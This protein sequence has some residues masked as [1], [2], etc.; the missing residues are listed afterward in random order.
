MGSYN[1]ARDVYS[2]NRQNWL[3]NSNNHLTTVYQLQNVMLQR[4][5]RLP[6]GG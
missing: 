4:Y 2:Y 5:S 3:W 1:A 6:T